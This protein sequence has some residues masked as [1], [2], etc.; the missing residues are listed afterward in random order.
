[1]REA[2]TPMLSAAGGG[3]MMELAA[4]GERRGEEIVS[5][6]VFARR[7]GLYSIREGILDLLP[8]GTGTLTPAQWSNLLPPTAWLYER[9]W[10]PHAVGLLSRRRIGLD[11]ERDRLISWLTPRPGLWLDLAA[12]TGLYGRW[13]APHLAAQG[14]EIVGLDLSFPML[15][16]AQ[17]RARSEGIGNISWV[18]GLAEALPCATDSVSGLV[19]GGSLN[20]FGE[21]APRVLAEVARVL[22]PEGRAFFMFLLEAGGAG[23]AAARLAEAG[24]IRFWSRD[25]AQ[26]LFQYAGLRLA[27][28]Q[29]HGVV[30]FALLH[31]G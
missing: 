11:G 23:R 18:R 8:R 6:S 10:R 1:M 9:A 30:A 27:A 7:R 3:A 12:S 31:K 26:S 25:G 21:R 24:G 15:R 14:A 28:Y 13:L 29:A 20:E 17:Q 4:V 19:C 22:R 5:G 16:E 2:V